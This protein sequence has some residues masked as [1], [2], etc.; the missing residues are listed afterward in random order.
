[1]N[2]FYLIS[3]I[4]N[5]LIIFLRKY[6]FIYNFFYL[7]GLTSAGKHG[8]GLRVKGSKAKNNRP[9]RKANWKLRNTKKLRRYR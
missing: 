5:L 7:I 3:I 9:S 6:T 4:N 1:M 8:R 2:K